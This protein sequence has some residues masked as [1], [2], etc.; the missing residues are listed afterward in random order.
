MWKTWKRDVTIAVITGVLTIGGTLYVNYSSRE[1]E[2]PKLGY[3]RISSISL[4]SVNKKVKDEVAVSYKQKPIADLFSFKIG[5][6]NTGEVTVQKP[7]IKFELGKDTEIISVT[8]TLKPEDRYREINNYAN[9]P[10]IKKKPFVRY[11]TIQYLNQGEEVDFDI[12]AIGQRKIDPSELKIIANIEGVVW[13]EIPNRF[14]GPDF[15]RN[16]ST[17]IIGSLTILFTSFTFLLIFLL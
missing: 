14:N 5:V 17:D 6:I 12:N 7:T 2:K 13:Y 10:N 15:R 3:K 8:S 4:V 9:P 1:S 16:S 11:V